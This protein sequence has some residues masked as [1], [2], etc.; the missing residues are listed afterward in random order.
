[1]TLVKDFQMMRGSQISFFCLFY[2]KKNRLHYRYDLEFNDERTDCIKRLFSVVSIV[3]R[4]R[5]GG[6]PN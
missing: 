6:F 1:M 4:T 5:C 2:R 3:H